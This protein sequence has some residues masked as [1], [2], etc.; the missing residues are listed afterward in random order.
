LDE[1]VAAGA[2]SLPVFDEHK[3][4]GHHYDEESE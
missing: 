4:L 2:N 3:D 1:Y